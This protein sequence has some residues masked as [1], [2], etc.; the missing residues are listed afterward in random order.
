M[1]LESIVG[2][3]SEEVA[4]SPVRGTPIPAMTDPTEEVADTPVRAKETS[5]LPTGVPTEEVAESPV[6]G[7]PIPTTGA[8]TLVVADTPLG[9]MV[10]SVIVPQPFSPQVKVPQPG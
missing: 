7:T 3:P 8:P 10:A 4:E 2:A 9:R 6:S 1:L 5:D